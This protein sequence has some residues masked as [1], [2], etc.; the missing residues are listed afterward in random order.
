MMRIGILGGGFQGC[1]LAL[2]IAQRGLHV[3][4]FD[5]NSE[6]ISRAGAANEGKIHLGYMYA[7][8]PSLQTAAVMARGALAFEPFIRRFLSSNSRA[9]ET[10]SPAAYVVHRDSQRTPEEVAAY[11]HH[12]HDIIIQTAN[13]NTPQYFDQ[14]LKEPPRRWSQS[15]RESEFDG[16]IAVDAYDTCEVAI[17]PLAMAKDMQKC[18]LSHPRIEVHLNSEIQTAKDNKNAIAVFGTRDRQRFREQ[19]DHAV[20]AS[21]DGRLALDQAYGLPTHQ[22]WIHRL[23]YGVS[24]S[25]PL[26]APLPRSAT[27]VSGPFGEVVSFPRGL[28]YLTWYPV[29]LREI[30]RAV[31]PPDWPNIADEPLRGQILSDTIF[32]MSE[33]IPALRGLTPKMFPDAVVKGGAIVAVGKTDIYDPESELHNRYE[34]GVT[35]NNRYHSIDPGKLTMAPYFAQQFANKISS[36]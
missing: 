9:F 1:C 6:L 15:Q 12:A 31:K 19:F 25:L 13:G 35:S 3:A 17:N 29:C 32:Q 10:S 34:I 5:K 14:N 26:N 30:T 16:R 27:F 21:W 23:K 8:D 18:V 36:L 24:I 7:S 33:F 28:T 4:L 22:P 11:I 20:N 2:A